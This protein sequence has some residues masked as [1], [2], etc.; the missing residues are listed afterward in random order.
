[1]HDSGQRPVD[2]PTFNFHMLVKVDKGIMTGTCWA[3][4]PAP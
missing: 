2:W 4:A 1:M 3:E